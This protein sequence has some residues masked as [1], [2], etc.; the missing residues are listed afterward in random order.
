MRNAEG[1]LETFLRF[2]GRFDAAFFFVP[3][4]SLSV[5][6]LDELLADEIKTGLSGNTGEGCDC[7]PSCTSII[8]NADTSQDDFN[9]LAVFKAYGVDLEYPG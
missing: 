7:L 4:Y 3:Y 1:E 8:Y 9:W 6:S 2:C 5:L